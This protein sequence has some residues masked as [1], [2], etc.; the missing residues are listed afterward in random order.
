MKKVNDIVQ[1]T[2]EHKVFREFYDTLEETEDCEQSMYDALLIAEGIFLGGAYLGFE[3]NF[4][5]VYK[6][7]CSAYEYN[8]IGG[9]NE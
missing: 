9:N 8:K 4:E 1:M 7:L 5:D 2:Y 6:K 3:Y